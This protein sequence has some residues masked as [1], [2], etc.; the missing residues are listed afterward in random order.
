[1]KKILYVLVV[2]ICCGVLPAEVFAGV[3]RVS[4]Y[5]VNEFYRE[6]NY[7]ANNVTKNYITADEYPILGL[8]GVNYNNYLMIC[9]SYGKSVAVILRANKQGHVSAISIATPISSKDTALTGVGALKNIIIVLGLPE[10]AGG[11]MLEKISNGTNPVALYCY[12]TQR[13]I[14]MKTF[15]DKASGLFNVDLYAAV[16]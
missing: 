3:V 16:D 9:G 8:D 1:M 7:V 6:Y 4:D 10:I 5:T 2:V 15:I 12:S 11:A 13:Y 14:F